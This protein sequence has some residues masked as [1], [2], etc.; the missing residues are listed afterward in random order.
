[1]NKVTILLFASLRDAVGRRTIDLA[2]PPGATVA[3]L[4]Q[5]LLAE[6]P[7]L[8]PWL[9]SVKVAVDHEYAG[10]EQAIP[11]NAEIALIPPVSGG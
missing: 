1:M 11:E 9:E 4:K 5:A 6:Y 3:D 2:L 8:A 10:G 7:A